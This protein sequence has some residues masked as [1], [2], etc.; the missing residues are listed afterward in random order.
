MDLKE[1]GKNMAHL[2]PKNLQ[3]KVYLVE[4]NPNQKH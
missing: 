3:V 1:V 2:F 4:I